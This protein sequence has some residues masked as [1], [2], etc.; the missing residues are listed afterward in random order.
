MGRI[1]TSALSQTLMPQN[2]HYI[3]RNSSVGMITDEGDTLD[4]IF[5]PFDVYRKMLY[6]V[7]EY[8]KVL[9][10]TYILEK[11]G[12]TIEAAADK[13]LEHLETCLGSKLKLIKEAQKSA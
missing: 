10:A 11:R 9:E 3:V 13:C 1:R 12:G 2:T 6:W 4:N 5:G 8:K 7:D